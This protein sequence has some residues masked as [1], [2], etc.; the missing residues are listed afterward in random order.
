M[1]GLQDKI[2]SVK[3]QQ[4]LSSFIEELAKNYNDAPNLW[5]NKDIPT[6]LNAMAAWV[7]DMDAFYKNNDL[8]YDESNIS[9]KNIADMLFAATIYE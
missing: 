4:Q 2:I 1:E 8:P 6:F 7:E 3:S 5:E 9:W